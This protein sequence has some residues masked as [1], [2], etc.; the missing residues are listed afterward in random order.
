[1]L[2]HQHLIIRGRILT[3]TGAEQ[4]KQTLT[5]I[6]ALVQMKVL[7]EAEAL[8][9]DEPDNVGYTGTVLLTTSHM[10]W[11]DWTCTDGRSDFQFD[12]YSCAPFRPQDVVQFLEQ[13]H[14]LQHYNWKLFDREY[15]ITEQVSGRS[16]VA[17]L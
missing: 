10:A 15:T 11:H 6:V 13:R 12:L 9:C 8:H 16:A 2:A 5:D 4:I 7:R 3:P 14:G 1:M 17:Y